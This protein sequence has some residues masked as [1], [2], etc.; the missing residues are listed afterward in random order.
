MAA[1]L[2]EKFGYI[3]TLGVLY[4]NGQIQLGQFAIVAP[5]CIL[6]LL[7][8]SAFLKTKGTGSHA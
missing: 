7:F 1:A 8:I 2:V 5:D 3:S 6:G 4:A